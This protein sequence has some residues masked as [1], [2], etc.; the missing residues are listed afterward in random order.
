MVLRGI[1]SAL[2]VG[3]GLTS[4]CTRT[5]PQTAAP[6]APRTETRTDPQ[7]NNPLPS[8][9]DERGQTRP[10]LVRGHLPAVLFLPPGEEPSPLLVASHGAGGIPEAECDYWRRLTRDRTIVVCPRG[11]PLRADSPSGFFYKTHLDLEREVTAVVEAVRQEL[12]PRVAPEGGTYAGFSQGAIMG[13]AMI[14]AHAEQ[15][16]YLVLIEGGYE[17]WSL[18][19]ARTFA[20]QGGKRVVF[21]C[22]TRWCADK[23]KQ[24]ATWLREAGVEVR[25]ESAPETG[26]TPGGAVMEQTRSALPWLWSESSSH[27]AVLARP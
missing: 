19:K 4:A 3:A 23:S 14:P 5:E 15:F 9:A 1:Q 6:T 18:R 13:A 10:L 27:E 20:T 21:S 22:G 8:Q 24:P 12:G 2:L 7:G 25:I 26:H 17:Y 16:P 11:V